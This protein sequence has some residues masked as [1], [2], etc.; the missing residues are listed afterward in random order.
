MPV[1][2]VADANWVCFTRASGPFLCFA[3]KRHMVMASMLS[4]LFCRRRLGMWSIQL[5][6]MLAMSAAW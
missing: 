6:T 1:Y 5:L 3:F 4:V 2:A